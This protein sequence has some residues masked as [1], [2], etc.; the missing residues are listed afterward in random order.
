MCGIVALVGN[1]DGFTEPIH[2]MTT[3]IVHRGPDEDGFAILPED[4]VALGM[5]RLSVLDIEGGTQPMWDEAR[6]H[7]VVYNGEIYN[8]K[9]IRDDLVARG[10]RFTTHSDTEVIVHGYEEWG[11]AVLGR[12]NGM[13]AIALWDEREDVLG[14]RAIASA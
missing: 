2:T 11:E 4:G 3:T 9:D 14:L 7:V 5:R 13:F 1:G 10:H 12:L 8:F 6:R